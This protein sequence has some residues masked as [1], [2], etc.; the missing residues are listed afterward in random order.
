MTPSRCVWFFLLFWT[1]LTALPAW[2]NESL[3]AQ[4]LGRLASFW[5]DAHHTVTLADILSGEVPEE[6]WQPGFTNIPN[7]GFTSETYWVRLTVSPRAFGQGSKVLEVAYPLLDRVV[8]YVP[9]E[10]GRYQRWVTGDALPFSERPMAHRYFAVPLE[11]AEQ[12]LTIYLQLSSRDTLMVP[13]YL[14]DVSAFEHHYGLDRYWFG[15]Y[16]GAMLSILFYNLMVY[17]ALRDQAYIHYVALILAFMVVQLSLNG[18]GAEL[19]WSDSPELAKRV[20]ALA[21]AYIAWGAVATTRYYF[22]RDKLVPEIPFVVPLLQVFAWA[23]MF[24]ALVLPFTL[25]IQIAMISM[26]L[27]CVS[28]LAT[29]VQE[30]RHGNATAVYFVLGIAVLILGGIATVL[31][32]FGWVPVNMWTSYSAQV[33]SVVTLLLLT[34]GLAARLQG[35]H[36][37]KTAYQQHLLEQ[38]RAAVRQLDH[39]VKERTAALEASNALVQR[40]HDNIRVLLDTLTVL[41]YRQPLSVLGT[42][43]AERLTQVLPEHDWLLL[44]DAKKMGEGLPP[45]RQGVSDTQ[46]DHLVRLHNHLMRVD[47]DAV[48]ATGDEGRDIVL[49]DELNLIPLR[50]DHRQRFGHLFILGEA[51]QVPDREVVVLFVEQFSAFLNNKRLHDKLSFLANRDALTGLYNRAYF[52]R[53]FSLFRHRFAREQEIFGVVLIDVNGLKQVNDQYGHEHGDTMIRMTGDFLLREVRSSDVVARLGGD[54]FVVLAKGGDEQIGSL[55]AK[56]RIRQLQLHFSFSNEPT[57]LHDIAVSMS[58][59]YAA[60]DQW[61]VDELL[62]QADA[63]MYEEKRRHYETVP[64]R[65][66]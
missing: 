21:V 65:T 25:A 29:G 30:A 42:A 38:E 48:A 53:C 39:K 16:Y 5:S 43:V 8:F 54:E 49:L 51:L 59:G 44:L 41:D 7:F 18:V 6:A 37:E 58:I 23:A 60:C 20:R 10:Q 1:C 27:S 11:L 33:G 35:L 50:D 34:F 63:M 56:L 66:V 57:A 13:L 14:W 24:G 15:A 36:K 61:P 46:C 12:P 2:A 26:L 31:R 3:V 47:K 17:L 28:V 64:L 9:D 19:L 55:V 52:E 45:W 22:Q 32:A 4:G 62:K 40:K